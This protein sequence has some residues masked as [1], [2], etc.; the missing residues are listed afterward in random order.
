V[1]FVVADVEKMWL[2]LNL[3]QEDARHLKLGQIV[4]FETDGG[5]T[6]VSGK[7][8]WASTAVDAK[9]RTI[10]VRVNL[11][12]PEGKLR[13]N[14]YG[15][16][17]VVLREETNAVVVPKEAVQWEGCCNIV[18]VR[19]KDFLRPDAFK[20][21]HVRQVR[22]GA[23]DEQH[24]ELLAGVLPGEIVVTKGTAVLRAELLKS[25]LGAG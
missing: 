12:N 10:K 17:K 18:F 20:V 22:P 14:S 24:V 19:D 7:V 4:R 15:T 5:H 11:T 3:S 2:T 25:K 8:A 9:S 16:G 6:E 13:A 1:Q 23:K 21:F